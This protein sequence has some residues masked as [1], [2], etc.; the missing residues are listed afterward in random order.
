MNFY[1]FLNYTNDTRI[2][3]NILKQALDR[4]YFTGKYFRMCF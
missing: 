2:Y 1:L 3:L 4:Y